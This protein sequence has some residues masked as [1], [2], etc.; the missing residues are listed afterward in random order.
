MQKIV[1]EYKAKSDD[2]KKNRKKRYI[3][4]KFIEK[5]EVC[6]LFLFGSLP[7]QMQWLVSSIKYN[8]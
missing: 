3:K 1:A 4:S 2:E 8:R 5:I 6:F 7:I